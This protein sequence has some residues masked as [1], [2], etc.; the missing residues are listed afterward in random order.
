MKRYRYYDYF[1]KIIFN[2]KNVKEYRYNIGHGYT[3]ENDR[4]NMC[5]S[6]GK[7]SILVFSSYE[8]FH[9]LGLI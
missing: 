8:Q 1:I 9:L 5:T 6:K 2:S 7:V 3:D 4:I